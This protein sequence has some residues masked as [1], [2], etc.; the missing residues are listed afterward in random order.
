MSDNKNNFSFIEDAQGIDNLL[1]IIHADSSLE[2]TVKRSESLSMLM[3][4]IKY[5]QNSTLNSQ[6]SKPVEKLQKLSL[7]SKNPKQKNLQTIKLH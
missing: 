6:K 5:I 7:H 2:G 3:Q 1:S 4:S